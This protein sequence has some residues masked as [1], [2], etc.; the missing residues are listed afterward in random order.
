MTTDCSSCTCSSA[1]GTPGAG[2]V[3]LASHVDHTVN[4]LRSL[5][6][7]RGTP[8][9]VLAP[10]LLSLSGD[11][12]GAFV[13]AARQALSSVEAAEVRCLV[14]PGRTDAVAPSESL[15][16]VGLL[17]A[18]LG[19][20]TLAAAGARVD[21]ASLLPLFADEAAAFHAVYQPIVDLADRRTI[22]HEALLRAVTPDGTP[23]YP[24]QL[25]PAAEAAGWTNLLDRVGRTTALRDA[26]AWLGDDLLF[27]NFVPT[28]IYRPEVCLRTTEQAAAAA[29]VRLDQIVFEV[30]EGH[31]V[32]D[33]DHLEHVFAY[34]R[35]RN[36]KV[37]LDDLG[38]GYSSLNTLVRLRPD[39][40]KLD[41]DIV[42]ELPGR[43]AAAVVEAI[44]TITHAYGGLVLAECVET[45]EQAAAALELGVD[46]GQGWYFGKPGRPGCDRQAVPALEETAPRRAPARS[47]APV[48]PP[49]AGLPT[50]LLTRALDG[51]V[52]GMSVVD[53]LDPGMPAVFVNPALTRMTGYTAQELLGRNMRLLQGPATDPEAVAGL[54]RALRSGQEHRTVLRNYRKDGSTWWN[55]LQLS[56]VLGPDGTATHYLGYQLDVTAR[57]EAQE[58]LVRLAGHDAL[59]GLANRSSLFDGL[60][61][62]VARAGRTG[63]AVAVV[64]LDLD[65]F[66]Q[67]NDTFGHATGDAVLSQVGERLDAALRRGDVLA[68]IGGDEFVAVLPD[69]D[70]SR[71][72]R[73]AARVADGFVRALEQP[74]T[75][76][77]VEVRLS[78][79]VGV[80]LSPQHALS[81]D[82]LLAEADAAMYRAKREGAGQVRTAP[83]ATPGR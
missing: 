73:V 41:K 75:A 18:A 69:L 72:E 16:E 65:G 45:A 32:Q 23:V 3:L 54:S 51:A 4:A 10:G 66:K 21:N 15:D 38:A 12:V 5:A 1:V 48:L 29:G 81:A 70:P 57:V 50:D 43:V 24:D 77:P 80:A 17:A 11:D 47:V 28:S 40:V 74:L 30:T 20:P 83:G 44:V 37:A 35:S 36:C 49:S 6:R 39:V 58:E 46:L 34:Y 71:A 31:Q 82:R 67:V 52:G 42:Q 53:V 79:S 76:G 19:A 63:A 60:E 22:G 7:R 62:S 27:I 25:F 68:R 64:F 55:E 61:A 2:R 8:A 78:G 56:P 59:T 9:E 13:T 14:V 33:L 26:G